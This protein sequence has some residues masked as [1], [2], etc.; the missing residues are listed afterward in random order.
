MQRN[1]ASLVY[2]AFYLCLIDSY[3]VY[4]SL[5][6]QYTGHRKFSLHSKLQSLSF[7]YDHLKSCLHT[8]YISKLSDEAGLFLTFYFGDFSLKL[9]L[10]YSY[11]HRSPKLRISLLI[12]NTIISDKTNIREFV[13]EIIFGTIC[14]RNF[15][16]F[17]CT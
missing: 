11:F 10:N 12:R 6:F 7:R 5:S 14:Q 8:D 15:K 4:R 1:Q 16:R 17:F 3:H 2:R 9:F 13:W